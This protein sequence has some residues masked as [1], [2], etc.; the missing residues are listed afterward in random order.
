L[1]TI[2]YRVDRL[3]AIHPI[4]HAF[5]E[6]RSVTF[7]D[8]LEERLIGVRATTTLM[9][10]LQEEARR[11]GRSLPLKYSVASPEAALSLVASG[12]GVTIQ[13]ECMISLADSSRL[14]AVSIAS[15]WAER[16]IV[17]GMLRDKPLSQAAKLLLN[18]I[19]GKTTIDHNVGAERARSATP[20]IVGL[21]S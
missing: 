16:L 13:P 5:T 17:I 3:V 15:E 2:F 14:G 1:E 4:G 6:R 20:E 10:T 9:S 21:T 19:V 11:A 18:H 7:A 12:L 8:L